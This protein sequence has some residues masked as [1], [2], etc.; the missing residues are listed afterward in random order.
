MIRTGFLQKKVLLYIRPFIFATDPYLG[1]KPSDTYSFV[2][3]TGPVG[4]Y[5]KEG[6]NPVKIYVESNYVRA[7]K[8][9]LGEAKASANYAASLKAQEEAKKKDILK[10]CGL[11]VLKRNTLRK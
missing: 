2:I 5:Y 1:V 6:V 8:G 3:I 11:T 10:F 7:V 9:G 4:A